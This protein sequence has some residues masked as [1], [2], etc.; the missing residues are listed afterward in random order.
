MLKSHS[1]T[2]VLAL[3]GVVIVLTL[4]LATSAAFAEDLWAVEHM[5]N[6]LENDKTDFDELVVAG[7][8]AGRLFRRIVLNW[9]KEEYE[10]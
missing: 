4:F 8:R 10:T 3:T 5:Q 9:A 2:R 1:T 6:L 7:D